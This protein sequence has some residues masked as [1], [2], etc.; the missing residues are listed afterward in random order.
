MQSMFE[1]L[2]MDKA[3]SRPPKRYLKLLESL[4]WKVV[5]A[6]GLIIF[7]MLLFMP[8]PTTEASYNSEFEEYLSLVIVLVFLFYL[9]FIFFFWGFKIG[10]RVYKPQKVYTPK[11]AR[12]LEKTVENYEKRIT[13]LENK[14]KKVRTK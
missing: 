11:M 4:K 13:Q 9:I 5:F 10:V 6:L 8:T 14:I 3:I 7:L 12:K 2:E 1:N